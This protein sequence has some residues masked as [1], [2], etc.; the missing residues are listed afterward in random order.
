MP[1]IPDMAI[2]LP[3]LP[4]SSKFS[5]FLEMGDSYWKPFLDRISIDDPK[6]ADPEDAQEDPV[7]QADPV[8]QEAQ[9]WLADELGVDIGLVT[10]VEVTEEDWPNG[11]LGLGGPD[12]ACTMA[13]VSGYKIIFNVMGEEYEVRTDL[14]GNQI[15]RA[16]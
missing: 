9:E 10:V 8:V 4:K 15:R 5:A 1:E 6:P 13:F 12:E 14:N 3:G 11:C 7:S 2:T 16:E